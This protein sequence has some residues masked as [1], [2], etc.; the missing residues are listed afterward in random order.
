[1]QNG[2][3]MY[4]YKFDVALQKSYHPINK[5]MPQIIHYRGDFFGKGTCYQTPK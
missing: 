3:F 4:M 1:M 5:R 2:V